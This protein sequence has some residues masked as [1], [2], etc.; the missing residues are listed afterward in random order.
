[1]LV[2]YAMPGMTDLALPKERLLACPGIRASL[3]KPVRLAEL[4]AALGRRL[5]EAAVS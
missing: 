2:D 4:A 1:M 5:P 3:T